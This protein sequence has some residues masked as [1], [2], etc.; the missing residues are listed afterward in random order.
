MHT[1]H[2]HR[3]EYEHTF[4]V[5]PIELNFECNLEALLNI[6]GFYI[7]PG[8]VQRFIHKTLSIKS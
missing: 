3:I 6:Y 2:I 1:Q 4:H 7:S 5:P 8:A